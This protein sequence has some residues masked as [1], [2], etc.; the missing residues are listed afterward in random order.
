M[1]LAGRLA[2]SVLVLCACG[3]R[4]DADAPAGHSLAFADEFSDGL[5]A[6]W[7][8][9]D[10]PP[11]AS[12]V[13][14]IGGVLRMTAEPGNDL[15]ANTN[16]NAPRALRW[17]EGDFV[18][19][20]RVAFEPTAYFH[21]AGLLAWQD[22]RAFVRLERSF[23]KHPG[24][25]FARTVGGEYQNTPGADAVVV[26]A[27]RVDLRL[28]REGA[29]MTAYWRDA[30][31]PNG[32]WRTLASADAALGRRVAVGVA[33]VVE[34]APGRKTADFEYFRVWAP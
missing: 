7:E 5:G 20:T 4:L 18:I 9:V 19:E 34:H 31:Q 16:L 33:L 30:T 29:R 13:A 17:V 24:L 28:R 14:V 22:E 10:P 25:T 11:G 26:T 6:G 3:A 1:S 15:Y 21:G 8:V 12:S 27:P 23:Y 2:A 32:A